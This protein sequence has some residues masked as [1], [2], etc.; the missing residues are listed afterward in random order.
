MA[1]VGGKAALVFTGEGRLGAIRVGMLRDFFS[2]LP[3]R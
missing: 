1:R 2:K 3:S